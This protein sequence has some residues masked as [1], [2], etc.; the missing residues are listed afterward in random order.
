MAF[1]RS[2]WGGHDQ[3]RSC[4]AIAC[5]STRQGCGAGTSPFAEVIAHIPTYP[6]IDILLFTFLVPEL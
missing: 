1:W 4:L 6:I 2:W 3:L 5:S